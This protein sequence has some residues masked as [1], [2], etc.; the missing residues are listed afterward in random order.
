MD[1]RDGIS[2]G[3]LKNSTGRIAT[4]EMSTPTVFS[5]GYNP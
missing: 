2:A 3:F 1:Y 4:G 5:R